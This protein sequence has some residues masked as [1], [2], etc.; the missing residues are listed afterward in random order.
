MGVWQ[1]K[2]DQYHADGNLKKITYNGTNRYEIFQN[3]KLGQA[4]KITLPCATTNGC[5]TANSSG[6]N[7]TITLLTIDNN[8]WLEN[9]TDFKGFFASFSG[10][11][12]F[13]RLNLAIT[14]YS[15]NPS[16]AMDLHLG[17]GRSPLFEDCARG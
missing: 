9:T 17:I 13:Y 14:K 16:S 5:S 6:A 7:T 2:A 3:Y 11:C 12:D 10:F 15:L 4:Q 1:S 8:G